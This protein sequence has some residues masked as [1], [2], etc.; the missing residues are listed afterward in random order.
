MKSR[1]P[2]RPW[3]HAALTAAALA[4]LAVLATALTAGNAAAFTIADTP[5]F[6]PTPMPPNI[7]VTLDDSG[8]MRWAYAPDNVCVTDSDDRNPSWISRRVKSST[9]NPI[10]YDPNTIYTPPPQANGTPLSTRFERAWV[11]GYNTSRGSRDLSDNY[12]VT[13]SYNSANTESNMEYPS[14]SSSRGCQAS[15]YWA[16]NPTADFRGDET[17]GVPAYYYVY[18]PVGT[19]CRASKGNDSCYKLVTVS[20]RSGPGTR[21]I[22]GDG[23]IDAADQ[24]ERQNFANWYSFYRTRNLLTIGAA[25]SAFQNLPEDARVAWRTL[26]NCT[27]F[28]SCNSI[29]NGI[30]RWVGSP[31]DAG[32][33]EHRDNFYRWLMRLPASGGTP[34]RQAAGQVG[35]YFKSTSH[36]GP[37]GIDPNQSDTQRGTQYACRP[38]FH[39]LMT[40]GIWNGNA[41]TCSGSNCGEQD[42]SSSTLPDGRRFNP[43]TP[44]TQVYS[45][46]YGNNLSDVVFHYWKT[47]LRTD[48]DNLLIPYYRDRSGTEDFKYWNP[49]N[50]PATWQH[51]VTFTVGLGLRDTLNLSGLEW[52]GDTH[53]GRGYAN[54]RSG[55]KPWPQTG[56]DRS[57]GNVYDLWHAAINS[58]G[59]AFAAENPEELT[60]ALQAALN[61]IG[62]S[63]SSAA[64][65]T[66]N[67]TQ[68]GADSLVFQARFNTA[69]WTGS[70]T[71]FN[72][73]TDGSKGK[74]KWDTGEPNKIPRHD[75]RKIY[76]WGGANKG[77]EFKKTELANAGLWGLI[78]NDDLLAYLRGDA[79]REEGKG[80]GFRARSARVG[81]IINSDPAFVGRQNYGYTSLPEGRDMASR[82]DVFVANKAKRANTVYVGANNGMLHAFDAATGVEKFAYVPQALLGELAQLADLKYAHRYFVDG[83]PS[84]WDAYFKPAKAWKTVLM[85]TTG[86]GGKSVFALDVTDP[87][88]FGRASVLWEIN[89]T[90]GEPYKNDLGRTL[91]QAVVARLNNGDWA[92]IFGNGYGSVN[93]RGVLYVVNLSTGALIRKFDTGAGSAAAPNGLG[94]PTLYDTNGDDIYD[95]VYAPDLLGNVWK[96]DFANASADHWKIA[97]TGQPL[98]TAT[99]PSTR[100]PAQP[101]QAR[102]E[103]ARPPQGVPGVLLLFGTGRFFATEDKDIPPIQ[104]FYAVLDNNRSAAT[105]SEL[106][107]QVISTERISLRGVMTDVRKLSQNRIDWARQRGW[108]MNLPTP[109]ERVIGQAA[110]R[111]GRV[112][113]ST[114]IASDDPCAFGGSGWLMEV[115]AKTGA[116]LPYAVFDTNGDKL[117]DDNDQ[118]IA[119]VPISVGIVKQPLVL[120]G[121]STA[122]KLMSGTSGEIQLERNRSFSE[123]LGRDSW[124]ELNR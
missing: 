86:A 9:F 116:Q 99:S 80:G 79:S 94:T 104:S 41:G 55:A 84:A 61:R 8:S 56:S 121:A 111:G 101:I 71:A 45:S 1:P 31:G 97:L 77:I 102:I 74:A 108:T 110:V 5:P 17:S 58:R 65:L 44:D 11:N 105:R 12:K 90:S 85:G 91:G 59:Q 43:N 16:Q 42:N 18:D 15:E 82:Y 114:L 20:S 67:S 68:I 40:D 70:M 7:A 119:G 73:E 98:F 62:E 88:Q 46:S 113:F 60:K 6:L 76:T 78:D 103:L 27:S 37:Y 38:N 122:S 3:P 50:D 13:W 39:I 34:L 53:E 66:A 26:N 2:A 19:P 30:R 47:D 115:D 75:L 4:A 35:E 51:L 24:D 14:T 54:L 93:Q 124:K 32:N 87:D 57:P 63:Q 28:S 117:V 25:A 123:G 92:A 21:D 72:L 81:D 22:N 109:G 118:M 33:T 106:Q 107:Q 48:L 112:I 29:R 120:D 69:D 49:K 23:R 100:N 83:S 95:T 52:E 96:F 89:D 10:Y 64:A 36:D